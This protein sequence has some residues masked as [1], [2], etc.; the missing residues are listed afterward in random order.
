MRNDTRGFQTDAIHAGEADHAS[1]TPISLG[2][3]SDA[4][5]YRT[6]NPTLAAYEAKAAALDNGTRGVSA[7]CG[8][9]AV[10]QTL[11]TLLSSGSRLVCHHTV[12]HWN[13]T[14]R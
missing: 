11:L 10:S 2:A 8:M 4:V 12:Y 9:A 13:A 7:A 5:Y 1:S 14:R 3:T 6:G